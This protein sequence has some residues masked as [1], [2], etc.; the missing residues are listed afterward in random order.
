MLES[1]KA[2]SLLLACSLSMIFTLIL[3]VRWGF[4]IAA[5]TTLA[6]GI[7]WISTILI[8]L[9]KEMNMNSI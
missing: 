2:Y 4:E 9:I 5:C 7:I 8:D 1:Y 3:V 6:I